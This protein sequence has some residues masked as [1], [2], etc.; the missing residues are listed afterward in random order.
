M[1]F[2]FTLLFAI[3]LNFCVIR[4]YIRMKISNKCILQALAYGLNLKKSNIG[5]GKVIYFDICD[6][7]MVVWLMFWHDAYLYID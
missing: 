1:S 7:T 5:Y 6:V 3:E 2:I 4:N